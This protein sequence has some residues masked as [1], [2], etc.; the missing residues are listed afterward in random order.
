MFFKF[1][2][3]CIFIILTMYDGTDHMLV[4]KCGIYL[5]GGNIC[6]STKL[7]LVCNDII[8]NLK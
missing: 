2:D 4:E 6:Y 3:R 7:F 1:K 8:K 5:I